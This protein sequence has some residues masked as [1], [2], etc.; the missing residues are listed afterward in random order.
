ML[1]TYTVSF[2]G[3]REVEN[4]TAVERRLE[5]IVREVVGEHSY[6]EF[7]VGRNGA[8]DQMAASTV[9]RVKRAL[10]DE[11]IALVLVLPYETAEAVNDRAS[12]ECYY[13]SIEVS[14]AAAG[15]HFKAAIQLRNREMVR[16][17]DLVI[18]YVTH[19]TGGAYQSMRYAENQ[20]RQVCNIAGASAW[21]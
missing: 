6:V 18:C 3:H 21:R 2:F 12:L 20:G 4:A 15:R 7:L 17:S 13:D 11:R 8:F 1:H 16:R 5:R 19:A 9:H 10:G 14:E